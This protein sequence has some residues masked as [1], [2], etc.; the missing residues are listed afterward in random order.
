MSI[1]LGPSQELLV[2]VFLGKV[3]GWELL[4]EAVPGDCH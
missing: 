3:M 1:S 2:A 4:R